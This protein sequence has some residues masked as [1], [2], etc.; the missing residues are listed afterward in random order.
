MPDSPPT[1]VGVATARAASSRPPMDKR[2]RL[3]H[4]ERGAEGDA[5]D[6]SARAQAPRHRATDEA[7]IRSMMRNDPA[8]VSSRRIL[9][10]DD[11]PRLRLALRKALGRKGVDVIE[12]SDG[13]E[14]ISPLRAGCSVAGAIDACILDLRMSRLHGLEVL[15]QTLGRKVPVIVLT[16]HGSIPDAVEAMRLGAVNFVLKPVDADELWPTLQQAMQERSAHGDVHHE[17]LLGQ[18]EA[19]HQFLAKLDKAASTDES[20]LLLG[21]TGSGKELAARRVHAQSSRATKPFVTFNAACTPPQELEVTL[22]GEASGDGSAFMKSRNGLLAEAAEGTLFVDEVGA[23]PL[24][25]QMKL[26]RALEER[27]YRPVGT[28]EERPLTARICA[29]SLPDLPDAVQRGDFR[30][31][32]FYRLSVL[33][34]RVPPLRERG[35]DAVLIARAWLSR[36]VPP[37]MPFTL[38]DDAQA[39]LRTYS[40]PGNVR[41]LV[42]L[43]KRA[44]IFSPAHVVDAPCLREL[45]GNSP[46]ADPAALWATACEPLPQLHANQMA[47]GERVTLEALEREHISRLLQEFRNVSEVARIAGI[48]RRTLQRKMIAW[49]LRDNE[50][51]DGTGS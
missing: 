30:S 26:L 27:R 29:A 19:L 5:L 14:A 24:A 34:L 31:E 46:F 1:F 45:I 17:T 51:P 49:G 10:V 28:E 41:E 25:A 48:D 36:L 20:V 22:F 47:A 6:D 13:E 43:I 40:F 32:L 21:E 7:G 11:D 8:V 9:V 23:M 12:A 33:S 50:S 16:G 35:D 15:R 3:L 37:E 44:V 38:T 39:L 2:G 4:N 42:N 18:S